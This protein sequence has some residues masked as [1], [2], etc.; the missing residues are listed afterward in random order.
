[1]K[2][3]FRYFCHVQSYWRTQKSWIPEKMSFI[4]IELT[5][6]NH[7][8]AY[9]IILQ[10][11]LTLKSEGYQGNIVASEISSHLQIPYRT[12]QSVMLDLHEQGHIT[13]LEKDSDF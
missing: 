2:R 9:E 1:M 4:D 11:I 3:C 5:R 6:S 8:V 10:H 7:K 13:N 12:V